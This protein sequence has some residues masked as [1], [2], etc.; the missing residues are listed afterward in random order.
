[1]AELYE[2]LQPL[3]DAAAERRR[4]QALAAAAGEEADGTPAET[5]RI[6]IMGLPNVVRK[7][8]YRER[9]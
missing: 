2:A 9:G 4:A 8:V 7:T 6:A 1:M 3:V 5:L